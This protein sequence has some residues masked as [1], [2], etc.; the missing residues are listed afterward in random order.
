VKLTVREAAKVLAVSETKLYR[1]VDEETIP[2][3]MIQHHPLFHRVELLEWAIEME[4]PLETDL[5]EHQHELPLTTALQRGGGRALTDSFESIAAALPTSEP[6]R[7][8]IR[9]V[10]SAR[11]SEMFSCREA[12]RLAIPR[13]RSP[14]VCPDAA[15]H[16]MLW[17]SERAFVLDGIAANTILLIVAPTVRDHLKLLSRLSR[18]LHDAAFVAALREPGAFDR[19]LAEARRLEAG[20]DPDDEE[21]R[22]G[23]GER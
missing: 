3:V 20:F 11:Q 16:V 23:V 7:E 9:A 17:W 2:F 8:R 13:A 1:W 10:V 15:A 5:Y 6:E 19:V 21:I 18:S 12:D 14:I 22:R 4:I